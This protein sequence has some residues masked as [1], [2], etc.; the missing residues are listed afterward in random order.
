MEEATN[1]TESV[2]D[3]VHGGDVDKAIS[4]LE[5]VVSKLESFNLSHSDLQ[6]SSAL[7]DL[8]K[9]YNSKGFSLKADD[10]RSRALLI[11]QGSRQT[12]SPQGDLKIAKKKSEEDDIA[13]NRASTCNGSSDDDWEAIADRAPDELL[14][15]EC[16][17]GVS[18]LSLEETKVQT[19]KR[20]GRGTFSYRKHGLYSD[21]QSD[22]SIIDDSENDDVCHSSEGDKEIRISKYGTR[23]VLVLADFPPSTR[24]TD[25]EKLLENFK[26]HGVVIRWVNDTTAL[27]VFRTPSVALEACNCIQCPFTVHVLDENDILLSSIPTRDL[28]P[29]RQRPETSA[30]TAKRLIA[31]GM[32]IKLP[33]T[34][35]GSTELR[36]QEEARRNRI[37]S[38]QNRRDEAW[39]DDVN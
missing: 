8:S 17:P 32:G 1:W 13:A 16:L 38:R 14:S 33:S 11:R 30:R 25:L 19:P 27:A 24:T 3:L 7:F 10:A 6:L 31:H 2:E 20:R 9:L 15:P 12:L 4:L 5:S 36:K 37:V 26:D 39:G 35:F 29:P 18:K 21:Q 23:H 28:E 34:T 22:G